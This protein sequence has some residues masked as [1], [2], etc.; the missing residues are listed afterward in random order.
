MHRAV[1]LIR[2]AWEAGFSRVQPLEPAGHPQAALIKVDHWLRRAQ[3]DLHLLIGRPDCRSHLLGGRHE[4]ALAHRMAVEISEHLTRS[5]QGDELILVE[6]HRLSLEGWP[7]LY[8]LAH[9]GRECTLGGLPTARTVLDLGPMLCDFHPHRRQ[10]KHLPSLL[11]AGGHR[12]QRGPTVPTTLDGVEVEVVRLGHGVQRMALVAW[13]STALFATS[14]AVT[15]RAVLLQPITARGLAAVAAVLPQLVLE[16]VHP[17]LE[18]EDEGS[19]HLYHGQHG[20]FALHIGGMD[21]VWGRQASWCHATH[22]ALFLSAV[23]EGMINFLMCLSSH[24]KTKNQA[25][26][27]VQAQNDLIKKEKLS[28]IGELTARISHDLQNPLT[29]ITLIIQSIELRIHNKMDPKVDEQLPLL[30]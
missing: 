28:A 2:R 22:Y 25:K 4:G 16:G 3:L 20:F 21:I 7:V 30:N 11:V 19:Q 26:M 12:L 5:F 15:A 18:G 1:D 24:D 9:L 6:I 10:L 13:L 8:W 27:I 14:G 29:I 17:C 23:H